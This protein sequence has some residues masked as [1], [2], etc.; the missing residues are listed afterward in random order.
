MKKKKIVSLLMAALMIGQFLP[1]ET[2]TAFAGESALVGKEQLADRHTVAPK[3]DS[4]VPNA[5][6]YEY[7]K[8]ELAAFCHFG[9]NTFNEIEWGEKYGDKKPDEIFKLEEDFDA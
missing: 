9:P 5:N 6:Q 3:K 4:V 1:S 2:M 8:Q 7:Q